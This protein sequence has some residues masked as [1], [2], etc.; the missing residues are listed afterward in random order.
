MHKIQQR[1]FFYTAPYYS[2]WSLVS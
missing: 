2:P 1:T